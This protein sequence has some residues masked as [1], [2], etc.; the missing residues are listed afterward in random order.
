MAILQLEV[1]PIETSFKS[2]DEEKKHFVFIEAILLVITGVFP[3]TQLSI[4]DNVL[5]RLRFI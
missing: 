5:F 4:S 2:Y 1:N 3:D